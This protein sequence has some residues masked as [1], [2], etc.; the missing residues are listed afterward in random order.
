MSD[1]T[2][3]ELLQRWWKDAWSEGLW[4]AS[5]SKSLEGLAAA[6]AAW[7]PPSATPAAASQRHSIWQ[8]VMHMVFWREDA[9]ARLTGAPKPTPDQLARLNFPAITDVSEPAWAAAKARFADSQTR[10][11]AALA[12]DSLSMDRLKYM[13]PHDCYHFGQINLIRA[14]LGLPPIE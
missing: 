13:L 6:Q 8:I 12:D 10:I 4:A 5:W 2:E 9:L 7:S 3:R 14:M 1:M 11:G